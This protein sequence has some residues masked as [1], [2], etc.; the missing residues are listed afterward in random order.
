M[1]ETVGVV[2]AGRMGLPIIGHLARAGFRTLATDVDFKKQPEVERRAALWV[3]DAANLGREN[4]IVLVCGGCDSEVREVLVVWGPL[5][6]ARRGAAVSRV[7][8]LTPP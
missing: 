5:R 1:S 3:A 2:G 6:A 7:S 8:T 4:D